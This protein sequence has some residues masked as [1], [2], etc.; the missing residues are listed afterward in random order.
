MAAFLSSVQAA[1]LHQGS[2]TGVTT[3]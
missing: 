3:H 1:D 2:R